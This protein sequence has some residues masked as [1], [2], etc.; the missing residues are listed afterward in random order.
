MQWSY[1]EKLQRHVAI[2]VMI[3]LFF[4]DEQFSKRFIK[5]AQTAAQLNHPNII[6]IHDVGETGDS[7]YIVMEYLDGESLKSLLERKVRLPFS[8]VLSFL[9]QIEKKCN[10][11]PLTIS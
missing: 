5:E 4:R 3:P 9:L 6:T 1:Q 8:R 2:K 7:H 11:L 10:L